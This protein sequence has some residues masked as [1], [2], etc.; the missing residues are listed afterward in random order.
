M[1][2]YEDDGDP[3]DWMRETIIVGR[4][5]RRCAS[6]R[7][8]IAPG[9]QQVRSEW[10]VDSGDEDDFDR[11]EIRVCNQC[12]QDRV[13]IHRHEMRV[14]CREENSWCPGGQIADAIR[15][16]D[17]DECRQE[18]EGDRT[19]GAVLFWPYDVPPA[20]QPVDL[21]LVPDLERSLFQFG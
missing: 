20:V 19:G 15:Q 16:G 5:V 1:C 7:R 8:D 6:C 2:F 12:C 10:R 3:V 11:G 21:R 9:E 13:A 4:K 18:F 17:R 14:G